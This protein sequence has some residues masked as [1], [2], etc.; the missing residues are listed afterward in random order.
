MVRVER[1]CMIRRRAGAR[2]RYIRGQQRKI[3]RQDVPVR[4]PGARER[5]VRV[6]FGGALEAGERL[7]CLVLFEQKAAAEKDIVCGGIHRCCSALAMACA[8]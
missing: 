6:E 7:Q 4:D 3:R 2:I 8:I 1:Q 5:I